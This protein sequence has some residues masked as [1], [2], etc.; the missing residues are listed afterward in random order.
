METNDY[1]QSTTMR[2]Y[3][4]VIFRQKWVIIACFLTVAVTTF[5]GLKFKTKV[6][7][8]S[9]KML[10]SAEKQIESPY[11]RDIIG[12]QNTV[13]SLTQSEIV[14]SDAVIERVIKALALHRRPLDYEKKYGSSLKS[15]WVD[16]MVK[17]FNEK[18]AFLTEDQKQAY[19]FRLAIEDL[20]EQITVEPIRDT[21]LFTISVRD[22]SPIGAAILANVVSRAYVIFDLEQQ[23][24]ELEM[25]YGNKHP[26][27]LQI[28]GNIKEMTENLRGEPLTYTEAIGPA[29][30]K[31]VKQ[32]Q[33]PLEPVGPP[34]VVL[35]ILALFMG[36]F[37]GIA[38]AF[39]AEYTDQTFKSPKDVES[40]LNLP[41]L[42][43][44]MKKGIFQNALIND[45]K[46]ETIYVQSYQNLSDQMYMSIRDKGIKSIVFASTL[47]KEGT[48]TV[49]VNLAKYLADK[50]KHKV[51][52]IDAN[53]RAPE[54]HRLFKVPISPGLTTVLDDEVSLEK[55]VT[56]VDSNLRVLPAGDNRL[57]PVAVLDSAEMQELV[58]KAKEK[59]EIILFDCANLR[60]FKDAH[61]LSSASDGFVMVVKEGGVRQQIAKRALEAL[62]KEK[63]NI[64]GVVLNNRTFAI[65]RAIYERI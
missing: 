32:A 18:T 30:V 1:Q 24:V 25:K 8:A 43:S 7:K 5:I 61:I 63:V 2:D 19:R 35:F 56:E 41:F 40:F 28:K 47:P 21:D 12:Y 59:Y 52:I 27:V 14:K 11:Y 53:L 45:T 6:Y 17:Q 26:S 38:L 20:T 50:L 16:F 58:K 44:I 36:L 39:V 34:K 23:M 4:S 65:P 31:I 51:L 3:L 57:N 33:V 49:V 9:V 42:G 48:S 29:S 13:I 10:I 22:Y 37:L 64:L 15:L 62:K 60:R 55:A 54:I 46:A